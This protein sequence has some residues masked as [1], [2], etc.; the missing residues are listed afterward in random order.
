MASLFD[1]AGVHGFQDANNL[2][3]KTPTRKANQ[4]TRRYVIRKAVNV[5]AK[6]QLQHLQ[7]LDV[8]RY[9]VN[10]LYGREKKLAVHN[11]RTDGFASI[12]FASR[13][14][15]ESLTPAFSD[16][17]SEKRARVFVCIWMSEGVRVCLFEQNKRK[18]VAFCTG[19][20]SW[21]ANTL[22]RIFGLRGREKGGRW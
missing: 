3:K 5:F 19:I 22:L 17:P 10:V 18:P 16:F 15:G 14:D 7:C 12:G 21:L 8:E 4:K 2:K 6:Q 9:K 13:L 1:D 20:A 11:L